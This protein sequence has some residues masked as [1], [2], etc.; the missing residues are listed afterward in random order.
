MLRV[1]RRCHDN[2][3]ELTYGLS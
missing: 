2:D 1:T 3:A